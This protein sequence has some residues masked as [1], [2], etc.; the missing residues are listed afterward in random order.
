LAERTVEDVFLTEFCEWGFEFW[1]GTDLRWY[2]GTWRQQQRNIQVPWVHAEHLRFR[3]G[4]VSQPFA[5][6]MRYDEIAG[7][8][9]HA[10]KMEIVTLMRLASRLIQQVY[11]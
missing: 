8:P 3:R 11:I 5:T 2:C 10:K 4:N 6:H 7:D 9:K 1:F